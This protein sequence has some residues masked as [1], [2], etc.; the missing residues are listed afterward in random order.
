MNSE[1]E[2]IRANPAPSTERHIRKAGSVPNLQTGI[3]S[4]EHSRHTK[5]HM[6]QSS[7]DLL[8][9]MHDSS[10][11][12]GLGKLHGPP[13]QPVP[14]QLGPQT[15]LREHL[16]GRASS[17]D[18]D[19]PGTPQQPDI[20]QLSTD[21]LTAWAE[22]GASLQHERLLTGETGA[23]SFDADDSA[24]PEDG[25][26]GSGRQAPDLARSSSTPQLQRG[27]A[28]ASAQHDTPDGALVAG[29]ATPDHPSDGGMGVSL[30]PTVDAKNALSEGLVPEEAEGDDGND[31]VAAAE[32]ADVTLMWQTVERDSRLRGRRRA[33]TSVTSLRSS[34]AL[35]A[36]LEDVKW[37]REAA[38]QQLATARR[39]KA[40]AEEEVQHAGFEG[41][42][43]ERGLLERLQAA[44]STAA[45]ATSDKEQIGDEL[46]AAFHRIAAAENRRLHLEQQLQAE[47]R[48]R[49]ATE[50]A[51]EAARSEAEALGAK[52]R[53]AAK[54]RRRL[55]TRMEDISEGIQSPFIT[56]G[57]SLHASTGGWPGSSAGA[58]SAM[59]IAESAAATSALSLP[60]QQRSEPGQAASADRSARPALEADVDELFEGSLPAAP[61]SHA[62]AEWGV[63]SR[64]DAAFAT[65]K[66]E[67]ISMPHAADTSG[68]HTPPSAVSSSWMRTPSQ[69]ITNSAPRSTSE[70]RQRAREAQAEAL[71]AEYDRTADSGYEEETDSGLTPSRLLLRLREAR[72]AA[73]GAAS[74]ARRARAATAAAE[75][76]AA[77]AEAAEARL[78]AALTAAQQRSMAREEHGRRLQAQ[79][80]QAQLR[81]AQLRVQCDSMAKEKSGHSQAL[82][83]A[84]AEVKDWETKTSSLQLQVEEAEASAER[85]A[86]EAVAAHERCCELEHAAVGREAAVQ[87]A[88][89]RLEEARAAQADLAA[90][91]GQAQHALEQLEQVLEERTQAEAA[92]HSELEQARQQAAALEDDL[93]EQHKTESALR[94]QLQQQELLYGALEADLQQLRTDEN[95]LKAEAEQYRERE[96]AMQAQLQVLQEEREERVARLEAEVAELKSQ[97]EELESASADLMD[98]RVAFKEREATIA[99]LTAELGSV[100]AEGAAAAAGKAEAAGGT[101]EAVEDPEREERSVEDAENRLVDVQI[102][103]MAAQYDART[104]AEALTSAQEQVSD[105]TWHLEDSHGR[106]AELEASCSEATIAREAVEQRV[107]ELEDQV[108][109]AQARAEKLAAKLKA[110][111]RSSGESALLL[112]VEA[113]QEDKRSAE[114]QAEALRL[115]LATVRREAAAREAE[116]TEQAA[117]HRAEAEAAAQLVAAMRPNG[118]NVLATLWTELMEAHARAARAQLQ[119]AGSTAATSGEVVDDGGAQKRLHEVWAQLEAAKRDVYAQKQELAVTQAQLAATAAIPEVLS[120][121]PEGAEQ[122]ASPDSPPESPEAAAQGTFQMD[123]SP[124]RGLLVDSSRAAARRSERL[125]VAAAAREAAAAAAAAAPA[126]AP[127]P[128]P[129]ADLVAAVAAGSRRGGSGARSG[130]WTPRGSSSSSGSSADAGCT[131][132]LTGAAGQPAAPKTSRSSASSKGSSGSNHSLGRELERFACGSTPHQP[133]PA[134]AVPARSIDGPSEGAGS[135][136]VGADD[137]PLAAGSGALLDVVY[138]L[139]G[140]VCGAGDATMDDAASMSSSPARPAHDWASMRA[141]AG[142]NAEPRRVLDAGAACRSGS[143]GS[144]RSR[145]EA[146]S[147]SRFVGHCYAQLRGGGGLRSAAA[148]VSAFGGVLC[149]G[150]LVAARH[151]Q[152]VMA[153]FRFLLRIFRL[154]RATLLRLQ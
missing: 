95:A 13:G 38:D 146:M 119:R 116:I 30:A 64:T 77:A 141:A 108:S 32:L 137:D 74:G 9:S 63:R 115:K 23:P 43:I 19:S 128:E 122:S 148:G 18:A 134:A 47:A 142:S 60:A 57:Q 8:V 67:G 33:R 61:V 86:A 1:N 83:A 104:A 35:E 106:L 29:A 66:R 46:E 42:Q 27:V 147:V 58:S 50:R 117:V 127:E 3:A 92:L 16:Q 125:A 144:R 34:G 49:E 78:G 138:D 52:A 81:L 54:Q 20:A 2:S 135:N 55:L 71:A 151:R 99:D 105:L 62:G 56:H 22:K 4:P 130:G 59:A 39:E 124:I 129:P 97:C 133:P 11:P 65:P 112:Q 140:G 7:V 91:A 82:K 90:R 6:L 139:Q 153:G 143:A 12:L 72:A 73:A 14:M 114:T 76:R 93:H 41:F 101:E 53:R 121:S 36:L 21:L 75:A 45:S 98:L 25:P 37:Q 24:Q 68:F 136:M 26:S 48:V 79:L 5:Q 118:D 44:L 110:H 80:S 28:S 51:L 85:A 152:A 84:A 120:N 87:D 111:R 113:L 88:S 149:V 132:R 69:A 94:R 109:K 70:R 107:A 31:D 100:R 145:S 17:T 10:A 154:Y 123:E 126:A 96:R 102:E 103:L 15:A 40:A 89:V 131:L 150:L